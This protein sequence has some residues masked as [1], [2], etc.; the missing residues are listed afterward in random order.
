VGGISRSGRLHGRNHQQRSIWEDS[1]PRRNQLATR[2]AVVIYIA[3]MRTWGLRTKDGEQI[4]R[5]QNGNCTLENADPNKGVEFRKGEHPEGL[6]EEWAKKA[7]DA[8]VVECEWKP[9]LP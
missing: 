5:D 6:K 4:Y 8:L 1:F 7:S 2:S 3:N 9:G